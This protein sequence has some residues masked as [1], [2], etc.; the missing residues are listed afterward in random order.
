MVGTDW[1]REVGSTHKRLDMKIVSVRMLFSSMGQQV[2]CCSL[3]IIVKSV[4]MRS[5][6]VMEWISAMDHPGNCKDN[7]L[8]FVGLYGATARPTTL[9]FAGERAVRFVTSY[10]INSRP[11]GYGR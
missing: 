10:P 1:P 6:V 2:R 3:P 8:S 9:A 7:A 4:L 11:K 5:Y